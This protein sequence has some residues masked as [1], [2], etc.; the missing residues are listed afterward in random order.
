MV[1]NGHVLFETYLFPAQA[2][3]LLMVILNLIYESANLFLQT[4]FILNVGTKVLIMKK[5]QS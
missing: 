2:G 5:K 4:Q 1:Q 3:I